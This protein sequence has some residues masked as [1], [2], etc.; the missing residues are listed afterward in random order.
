MAGYKKIAHLLP[1][2]LEAADQAGEKRNEVLRALIDH[3]L[4]T[5]EKNGA[6]EAEPEIATVEAQPEQKRRG[7]KPKA[8]AETEEVVEKK[9]R[10]RKPKAEKE[11]K[12]TVSSASALERTPVESAQV[13]EIGELPFDN[14]GQ[15]MSAHQV[16]AD[17]LKKLYAY[18]ERG[19]VGKYMRLGTNKKSEAQL[20]AAVLRIVANALANGSF[21]ASIDEIKQEYKEFGILDT[22]VKTNLERRQNLFSVFNLQ[23]RL[24]LNEDGKR[25]AA[26]LI[27]SLASE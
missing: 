10:G 4:M 13:V 3:A 5:V 6:F 9:R 12:K 15:F 17:A 21:S 1:E 2:I 19:I 22:N 27:K 23:E 7:R 26:E 8:K 20:N 11:K 14:V 16:G 24:E 25:F 18:T